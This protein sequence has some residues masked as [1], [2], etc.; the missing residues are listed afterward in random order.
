M[1]RTLK[2]STKSNQWEKR[3]VDNDL[4]YQTES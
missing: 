3:T 4:F 1:N 2:I